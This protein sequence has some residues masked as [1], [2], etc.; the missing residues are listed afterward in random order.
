MGSVGTYSALEIS[1]LSDETSEPPEI[2]VTLCC[3]Q[4]GSYFDEKQYGNECYWYLMQVLVKIIVTETP[5]M[6]QTVVC[7]H[8]ELFQKLEIP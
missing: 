3:W 7:I 1:L 5:P 2:M 6:I 8:T 4:Y